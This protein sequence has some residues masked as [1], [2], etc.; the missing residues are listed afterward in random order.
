MNGFTPLGS[1][2]WQTLGVQNRTGH[3]IRRVLL[4]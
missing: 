3:V 1:P 4:T 2:D